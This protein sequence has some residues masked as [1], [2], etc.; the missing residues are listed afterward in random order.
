MKMVSWFKAIVISIASITLMNGCT[1]KNKPEII[2]ASNTFCVSS[3]TKISDLVDVATKTFNEKYVYD[4][5]EC[6]NKKI[7]FN[8]RKCFSSMDDLYKYINSYT[9][10]NFY[11][12]TRNIKGIEI[13]DLTVKHA[14]DYINSR[15]NP[16][17][18]V[19]LDGD[20][21]LKDKHR[22]YIKTL[23]GLEKYIIETS[24]FYLYRIANTEKKAIYVLRYKYVNK[25]KNDIEALLLNLK[26]ARKLIANEKKNIKRNKVVKR[27]DKIIIGV[28]NYEKNK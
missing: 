15:G 6:K 22:F 27:L 1:L 20:F 16:K 3:P 2:P 8:Q 12:N 14:I 24:P 18:I 9:D 11:I 10:Y 13:K 26:E 19:L 7:F 21:K 28:K 23:D 25:N 4:G 5:G 17:K